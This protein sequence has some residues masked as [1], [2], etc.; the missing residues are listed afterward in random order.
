MCHVLVC[1]CSILN[2]TT[3]PAAFSPDLI[4]DIILQDLCGVNPSVIALTIPRRAGSDP[5][6]IGKEARASSK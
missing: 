4:R 2:S 3:I 6:R 5:N 1:D